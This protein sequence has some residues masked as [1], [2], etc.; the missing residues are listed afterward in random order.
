ML[1]KMKRLVAIFLSTVILLSG[2]GYAGGGDDVNDES[3]ATEI[4][5][6]SSVKNNLL[7]NSQAQAFNGSQSNYV[8]NKD[9]DFYCSS[10]DVTMSTAYLPDFLS[11]TINILGS[12]IK[13]ENQQNLFDNLT[14]S[15]TLAE[16]QVYIERVLK[17]RGLS[18][19]TVKDKLLLLIEET[20]E[21]AK[22]VR[23]NLS[24]ASVDPSRMSNYDS[25]ESEIADVLIVLISIA[26]VLG[27]D[28]FKC[29][30]EK[31]RI[32]INRR[33]KIND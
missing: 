31:E 3:R 5:L 15:S 6:S 9:I 17:L 24:G 23:K 11:N 7:N 25:V 27:I 21:L 4:S 33:W 10:S 2:R 20:G 14:Q 8:T 13:M 30:K 12:D 18:N 32:N 22:A 26:N 19:Q 16:I 1:K 28:I 29:L